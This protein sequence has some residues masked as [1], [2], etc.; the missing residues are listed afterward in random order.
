MA[1]AAHTLRNLFRFFFYVKMLSLVY[2]LYTYTRTYNEIKKSIYILYIA[3]MI[4][5]NK[6]KIGK[7]L[8][9]LYKMHIG[10]KEQLLFWPKKNYI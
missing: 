4:D 2:S 1:K 3:C 9:A 8:R 6:R 5:A 7:L 10:K